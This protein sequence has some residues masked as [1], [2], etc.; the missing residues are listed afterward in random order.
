VRKIYDVLEGV[1]EFHLLQSVRSQHRDR[2][3]AIRNPKSSKLKDAE[4]N[5]VA[6]GID[7]VAARLGAGLI[8]PTNPIV[9]VIC[10]AET[11]TAHNRWNTLRAILQESE[12]PQVDEDFPKSGYV[13][14]SES[15]KRVGI[16][17]MPDNENP[18]MLEDFYLG[19]IPEDDR[20]KSLASEFVNG[21]ENPKF[22]RATIEETEKAKS[23][24]V[25]GVWLCIQEEPIAPGAAVERGWLSAERGGMP[26][27]IQWLD[28]LLSE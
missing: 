7:T 15:G 11:G 26:P 20:E 16:W 23:K 5:I 19:T 1:A 24:A 22:G 13:G 14:T 8:D 2:L 18:G 12:F 6:L 21:I 10:D 4:G 28:D 9:L 25:L 3:A 17:I 27:F